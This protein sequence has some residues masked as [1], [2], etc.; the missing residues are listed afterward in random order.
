MFRFFFNTLPIFC[1][2]LYLGLRCAHWLGEDVHRVAIEGIVVA[3]QAVHD[4]AFW[5]KDWMFSFFGGV[6]E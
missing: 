3:E 5:L 6:Q 4:S 1:V 2:G